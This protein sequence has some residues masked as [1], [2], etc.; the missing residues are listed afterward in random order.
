[1]II[2]GTIEF[3][4]GKLLGEQSEEFKTWYR[5]NVEILAENASEELDQFSR[6]LSYIKTVGELKIIVYPV[7]IHEASNNWAAY[8]DKIEIQN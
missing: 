2:E 8:M 4:P 1:M 3:E 7:Y 6:P 5:E